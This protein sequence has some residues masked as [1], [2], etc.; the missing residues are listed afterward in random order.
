MTA[1]NTRTQILDLA[2]NLIRTK[3][4]NSFSYNE[5]S[6][7]LNIKNAAIHYHFPSKESLG[8]EVIEENIRRFDLFINDQQHQ[9]FVQQIVN[10]IGI[11]EQSCEQGRV[12]IVG[13]IATEYYGLPDSMRIKITEL[14]TKISAFL[15][16]LL[17]KGKCQSAFQFSQDPKQKAL[18]IISNLAAS[19]Q[20]SRL[21]EGDVFQQIKSGIL[22]ELSVFNYEQNK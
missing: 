18:M 14:T 7:K 5:I 6:S 9:N 4:Y 1:V 20:L 2:E 17:D 10:F 11:Y 21:I 19:V 16:D 13:A 3:G 22:K 15:E 12:C 8:A